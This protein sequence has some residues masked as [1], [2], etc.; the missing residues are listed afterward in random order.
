MEI[1]E[2]EDDPWYTLTE[3]QQQI[4]WKLAAL[5]KE[6][7]NKWISFKVLA[8]ELY[9][10]KD[11]GVVRSTV[12]EYITLLEEM[13][14]VQKKRRGRQTYVTTTEKNPHYKE[15]MQVKAKVK[16]KKS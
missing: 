14:Y 4:C 10:N 15:V 16:T 1:E 11:Y 2:L 3:M 12:S 5:Q 7:P 9:P 8:G 6:S 13:G